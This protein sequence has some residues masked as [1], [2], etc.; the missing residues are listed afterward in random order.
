ML[1]T[2]HSLGTYHALV[3]LFRP[4]FIPLLGGNMRSFYTTTPYAVETQIPFSRYE[5]LDNK[6]RKANEQLAETLDNK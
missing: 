4:S 2:L 3:V 6:W 5:E 1:R